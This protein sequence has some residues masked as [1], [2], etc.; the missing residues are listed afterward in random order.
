MNPP[1]SDM[2]FPITSIC[3]RV[4]LSVLL[5][6]F[7]KYKTSFENPGT[8][9]VFA[10]ILFFLFSIMGILGIFFILNEISKG[11]RKSLLYHIDKEEGENI[12]DP[13]D[14]HKQSLLDISELREVAPLAEGMT[15]DKTIVRI[16]T[17]QAMEDAD[18]TSIR[19]VLIESK[20]DKSKDV[21]YFSHEALKKI[22]ESYMEKIK[23]LTDTINNSEPNFH[24]YKK[25]ADL[26][27]EFGHK[28]VDHPILVEF[29]RKEAIKYYK[30]LLV[31]YPENKNI[32]IAN[33][34][35]VLF[36]NSD[37]E[38]CIKYCDEIGNDTE[39]ISKSIEFKARCFFQSRKIGSLKRFAEKE[40]K[41]DVSAINNFIE[42]YKE[43]IHNG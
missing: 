8:L 24:D 21:Q 22:S 39:F 30:D 2:V 6:A 5:F 28:K 13:S 33:I 43:E 9:G 38:E 42:L 27:A 34:I 26:Y 23:K 16:A 41:S 10:S 32:I 4:L 3:I 36:E 29:Y 40:V 17:I 37:Y 31:N 14:Y 35:P 19:N 11:P 18:V 1:N 7:I 15:D 12:D 20:K 25:L